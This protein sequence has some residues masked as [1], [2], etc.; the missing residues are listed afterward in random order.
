MSTKLPIIRNYLLTWV[1]TYPIITITINLKSLLQGLKKLH[2]ADINAALIKSG[3]NQTIIAEGLGISHVSVSHVIYGRST[4][5]RVANAIAKATGL[6]IQQLW[7]GRYLPRRKMR[8][9]A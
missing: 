4:S 7:P 5:L 2:P 1:Q 9:A 3:T 6:T 8:N